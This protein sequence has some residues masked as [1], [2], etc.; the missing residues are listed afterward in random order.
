MGER[1]ARRM[2]GS[3]PAEHASA[4]L[5]GLLARCLAAVSDDEVLAYE[6][7]RERDR[8]MERM[9]DANV[10]DVLPP[11]MVALVA[12]DRLE[13][14]T[15]LDIVRRWTAYQAT[16][17]DKCVLALLGDMGRGKT[18]AA[19][20]LLAAEGGLYVEAEELSRLH[21]AKWG[22]ERVRYERLTRAGVLV[23]DELGTEDDARGAM[24]DVINRRQG[25][26]LTL[27]LGNLS[28]PDLKA[29]LDPRT[30]DRLRTCA[31]VTEVQGE[32]M[33]RGSL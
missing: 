21:A 29:R 25:R 3:D 18:V 20:W 23:V 4:E 24:R 17:G 33:R 13:P 19:A 27:L 6:R 30:W 28:K 7:E 5:G 9:R 31:V 16:R 8:R 11:A 12:T 14:S 10:L 22:D 2:R 1:T 32:S 15:A 26:R